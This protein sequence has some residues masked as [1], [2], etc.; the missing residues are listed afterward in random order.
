MPSKYFRQLR[1]A[2]L[3]EHHPKIY[4]E[5]KD[6][7]VLDAHLRHTQCRAL[8]YFETLIEAGHSEKAAREKVWREIISIH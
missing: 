4:K 1:I 5:L 2:Y 7:G 8:D 3:I 6:D